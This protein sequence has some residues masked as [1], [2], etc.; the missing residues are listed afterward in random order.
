M[1]SYIVNTHMFETIMSTLLT[2]IIIRVN[3]IQ[4][5]IRDFSM[6]PTL[7]DGEKILAYKVFKGL[8]INE[9]SIVVINRSGQYGS[10]ERYIIKRV[11]RIEYEY[12]FI[13]NQLKLREKFFV[14]G[15]N[16]I[17]SND[18]RHFGPIL[19][20]QIMAVYICR[21]YKKSRKETE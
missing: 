10:G 12:F 5:D 4:F 15:D 13:H 7:V 3:F 20:E 21:L 1:Q 6:S 14:V 17:E 8:H 9:G 18:S 11:I 16:F 2:L 19:R